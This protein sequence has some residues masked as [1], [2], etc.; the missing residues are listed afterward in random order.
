MDEEKEKEESDRVFEQ[1]KE[2]ARRRDADKTGKNRARRDKAKAR[3]EKA[4]NGGDIHMIEGGKGGGVV[5]KLKPK[6]N[7][8]DSADGA[9]GSDSVVVEVEIEEAK[10]G[11]EIGIIIHD[12]D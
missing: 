10:N 6:A 8:P 4:K 12:D 1:Q 7:V 11:D 3:K 9:N 5:G 2:E